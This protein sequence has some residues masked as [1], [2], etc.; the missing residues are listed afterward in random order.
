MKRLRLSVLILMLTL[1]FTLARA[2]E[3]LSGETINQIA[4]SVVQVV[5]LSGGEPFSQGSGTIIDPS[6][7]IFTNVHVIEGGDDFA[8]LQPPDLAEL[9][10]LRYFASIVATYPDLDFAILQID[11]DADGR[12]LNPDSLNLPALE[13]ADDNPQLGD[14]IFIFGYPGIGDGYLVFTNGSITT[15]Q[16]SD[17]DGQRLPLLYQT[18]A[19]ISPGNS[20]GTA[21]N[22]AGQFVGIPT[23]VRSEERTGGRLGG[24]VSAAAIR[25]V[26]NDGSITPNQPSNSPNN[27]DLPDVPENQPTPVPDLSS[28]DYNLEANYGGI[29]LASGFEPEAHVVEVISG[30]AEDMFVDVASLNLGQ[31]CLG[32]ATPQPDYKVQWSGRSE[33]LRFFFHNDE[34]GDTALIVNLPDGSW[35]CS[36]DSFD[37]LNPTVDV[38]DPAEGQYDIWVA[39]YNADENIPGYLVVTQDADI[40][41]QNFPEILPRLLN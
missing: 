3:R 23:V 7:Y 39:S 29:Q 20:G 40:T 14:P 15:I 12:G 21:V 22:L 26:L 38:L 16:N 19:E 13:I 27:Q 37:T 9:P 32:F 31:N 11:R 2:Q 33:G 4:E 10:E 17:F 18:D 28:L 25:F 1:P 35:L 24:V 36:D 8:I 30:V 34:G 5:A 41:P 6:G